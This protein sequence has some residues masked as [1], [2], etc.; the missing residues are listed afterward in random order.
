MSQEKGQQE[1]LMDKVV[2]DEKVV[3]SLDLGEQAQHSSE[4][5]VN[6][7]SLIPDNQAGL[8]SDEAVENEP[9]ETK[10]PV[11]PIFAATDVRE[12]QKV[13]EQAKCKSLGDFETDAK[14]FGKQAKKK[15]MKKFAKPK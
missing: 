15:K 11:E 14:P 6:I 10:E 3:E 13:L 1:M 4:A 8:L 7:E 9:D 2:E 5:V 12:K